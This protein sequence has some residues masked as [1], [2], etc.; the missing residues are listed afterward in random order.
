MTVIWSYVVKQTESI[1]WRSGNQY[2]QIVKL[3]MQIT[4]GFTNIN[5]L[6]QTLAIIHRQCSAWWLWVCHWSVVG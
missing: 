2:V 1:F 6:T 5:S 4:S 3:F